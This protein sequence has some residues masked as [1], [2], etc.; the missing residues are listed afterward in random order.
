M[1]NTIALAAVIFGGVMLYS[2]IANKSTANVIRVALGQPEDPTENGV[3]GNVITGRATASA[4]DR[5][6][7]AND[8]LMGKDEKGEWLRDADGYIILKPG[9]VP[10]DPSKVVPKPGEQLGGTQGVQAESTSTGGVIF[11]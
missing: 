6:G 11:V 8:Q 4:K 2:A 7:Y 5:P 1:K 3:G 9:A 10:F